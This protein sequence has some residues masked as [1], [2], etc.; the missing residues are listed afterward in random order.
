[1][2]VPGWLFFQESLLNH[3]RAGTG[4]HVD[5]QAALM[6]ESMIVPCLI[7]MMMPTINVKPRQGV[8]YPQMLRCLGKL[9]APEIKSLIGYRRYLFD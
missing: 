6:A 7:A 4:F 8:A 5:I 1:M 2:K 9:F 3:K